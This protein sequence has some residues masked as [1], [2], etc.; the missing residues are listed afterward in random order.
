MALDYIIDMNCEV[1]RQLTKEGLVSMIKQR[2]RAESMIKLIKSDGGSDEEALRHT[3]RLRTMTPHG[4]EEMEQ[5]VSDLLESTRHLKTLL[6]QCK[7]CSLRKD[8]MYDSLFRNDTDIDMPCCCYHAINYPISKKAEEWLAER[9]RK[10][11]DVGGARAMI[12]DYIAD[13]RISGKEFL[14]LRATRDNRYLQLKRSLDVCFSKSIINKKTINTDQ[15]LTMLFGYPCIN[16]GQMV[17]LLCLVDAFHVS[18]KKPEDKT[19]QCLV[20]MK[21]KDGERSFWS[22]TMEDQ[23]DDDR[24][25]VQFKE[26]FRT[27]FLACVFGYDITIDR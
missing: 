25:I 22:F 6:A 15:I 7:S 20:S 9:A 24:S 10:A 21:G 14:S 26:F 5:R 23:V 18:D 13:N 19:C 4:V 12:L 17:M 3:F 11:Q 1:K 2:Y 27:L 8:G 16:R